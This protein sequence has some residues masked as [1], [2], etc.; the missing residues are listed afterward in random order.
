[1]DGKVH[2]PGI[3]GLTNYRQRLSRPLYG[4]VPF[5]ARSRQA[6]LRARP[7]LRQGEVAQFI[8]YPYGSDIASYVPQ[9]ATRT[10]RGVKSRYRRKRR[11]KKKVC[12]TYIRGKKICKPK[13]CPKKRRSYRRKFYSW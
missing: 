8:P 7:P 6:V 11:S 12:C 10:R 4:T 5:G 2:L 9:T 1:M 3:V 13:F